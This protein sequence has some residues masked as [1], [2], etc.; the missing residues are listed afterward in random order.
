MEEFIRFEKIH[1]EFKNY[2]TKRAFCNDCKYFG[3]T[4]NAVDCF[5]N[6]YKEKLGIQTKISKPGIF[7]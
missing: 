4:G 6:F 1:T 7:K 5:K 3:K 2:C